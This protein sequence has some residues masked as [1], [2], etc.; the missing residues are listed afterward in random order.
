MPKKRSKTPSLNKLIPQVLPAILENELYDL[1]QFACKHSEP[2][3]PKFK[4]VEGGRP[5]QDT[6]DEFISLTHQG[7]RIAQEKIICSLLSDGDRYE[8]SDARRFSY[9][10]IS[11]AIGWQLFKHELAYAKRFF[12]AQ[13]PPVLQEANIESVISIV[14]QCHENDPDSIAL[15][16]DLTSFIQ[17]GDIYHVTKHGRTNIYEVKDGETNRHILD[18]LKDMPTSVDAQDVPRLLP[19]KSDDFQKQVQRVIRQKQRML[20][21]KETLLNNEGI[22]ASTGEQVKIHELPTLVENWYSSIIELSE[23]SESKGYAIDVIQDCLYIGCYKSGHFKIPGQIAFEAWFSGMGATTD[24]P[25]TSL[26][27]CMMDPLGLTIYNLPIPDDL[28]FDLLFGRKH[29]SLAIHIP[30]LMEICNSIGI[31]M[32]LADTKET[33]KLKQQNKY[34]WR[35]NGRAIVFGKNTKQACLGEGFALRVFYH[36]ENPIDTMIA[37]ASGNC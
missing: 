36:G 5:T 23:K 9:I 24:C 27:N 35:Y 31:P 8:V 2:V 21:V 15:I 25:R 33:A 7:M 37:Y 19:N 11:D 3:W 13:R 4:L 17:I 29:I 12:M 34:L 14:E 26:I 28:K 6:I 18:I 16:S 10:G 1:Y 22:D 20:S 30:R 32:R